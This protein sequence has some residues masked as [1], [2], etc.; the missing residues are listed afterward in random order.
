[1]ARTVREIRISS[2]PFSQQEEVYAHVPFVSLILKISG[3]ATAIQ[4][5]TKVSFSLL[6]DQ[7][8]STFLMLRPLNT[9]PHVVGTPSHKVIFVATL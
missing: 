9:V 4:K 3:Q 8:F 6:Q 7:W 1:M 5:V 2:N